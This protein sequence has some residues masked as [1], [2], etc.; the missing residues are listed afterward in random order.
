[1]RS[2]GLVQAAVPRA[3]GQASEEEIKVLLG[4]KGDFV[5]QMIAAHFV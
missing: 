2:K 1:M 4:A 5:F 3:G